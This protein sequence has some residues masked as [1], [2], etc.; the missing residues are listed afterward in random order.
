MT[1]K[2]KLNTKR[3]IELKTLLFLKDIVFKTST[4]IFQ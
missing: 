1:F 4:I 3:L 2:K